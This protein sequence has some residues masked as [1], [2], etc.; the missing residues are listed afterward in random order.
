VSIP[1]T[2]KVVQYAPPRVLHDLYRTRDSKGFGGRQPLREAGCVKAADG[3]RG[4]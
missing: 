1:L 2:E 3:G 4:A